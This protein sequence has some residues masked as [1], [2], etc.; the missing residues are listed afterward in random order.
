MIP[1]RLPLTEEIKSRV[2][3]HSFFEITWENAEPSLSYDLNQWNEQLYNGFESIRT[4]DYSRIAT[5][6]YQGLKNLL[7]K[8]KHQVE[9]VDPTLTRSSSNGNGNGNEGIVEKNERMVDRIDGK[10]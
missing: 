3:S 7:G 8:A 2:N 6:S 1:K 5:S 9:Q 10:L 4:T